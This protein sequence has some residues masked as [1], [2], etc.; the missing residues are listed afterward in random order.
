MIQTP[1]AFGLVGN[2][3]SK[4]LSPLMHN[5]ALSNLKIKA[6]YKLF[7]LEERE[8]K[9]FFA[10]LGK[11]NIRGLNVTIPYKERILQYINGVKNS[12]V[13][14]I[15]STNTLVIDNTGRIKFFNTD[16]LGFL[17]HITELKL[18]PKKVAIIGAGGA[19]KAICFALGKKKV[20]EVSIYDI[21]S[22]RSLALMK[23]FNYIFPDVRFKAVGSIEELQLKDNYLLIND[24]SVVMSSKDPLL[25]D[26]GMLHPDLFIYDLIYNPKETKL[27]KLAKEEGLKYSNG[28]GMLL[29]QGAESL[30]LWIRPRKAPVEVMRKVLE[31]GAK[32]L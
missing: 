1:I 13:S 15:G 27:L 10:N 26:H 22:F 14:S 8:L 28:L 30:S 11:K 3:I 16:Y 21:D 6:R 20:L 2:P 23:R 9:V 24:S 19:A 31:K 5:A 12:A 4:S 17:R 32:K 7:P 18:K 29:Y 25:V